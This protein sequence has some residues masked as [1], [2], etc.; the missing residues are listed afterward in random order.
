MQLPPKRRQI[1]S[2]VLKR[3][4]FNFA[5]GGANVV[6]GASTNKNTEHESLDIADKSNDV[7]SAG[8]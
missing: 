7:E 6:E 3:S 1:V 5:R 4:D 2:L 8:I